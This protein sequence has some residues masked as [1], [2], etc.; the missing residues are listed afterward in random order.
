MESRQQVKN[1]SFNT[2]CIEI[3]ILG[4]F[5]HFVRLKKLEYMLKN[6]NLNQNCAGKSQT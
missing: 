1:A 6:T 4:V 2:L 5:S 3:L